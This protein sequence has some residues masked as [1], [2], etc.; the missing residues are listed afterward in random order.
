MLRFSLCDPNAL[1]RGK[2]CLLVFVLVHIFQD[3]NCAPVVGIELEDRKPDP[4]LMRESAEDASGSLVGPLHREGAR[5]GSSGRTTGVEA[6]CRIRRV[7]RLRRS[8]DT[9][10]A[11]AGI[12]SK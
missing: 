12:S 7:D 11:H 5:T 2:C 8:G 4:E 6:I 9:V 10:L 3:L 1:L